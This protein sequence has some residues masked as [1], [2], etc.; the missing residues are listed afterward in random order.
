MAAS[1]PGLV[2]QI[3]RS[4]VDPAT[5]ELEAAILRAN[6][7]AAMAGLPDTLNPAIIDP[8]K[9]RA[10]VHAL[11]LSGTAALG[12]R[13]LLFSPALLRIGTSAPTTVASFSGTVALQVV[14][15]HGQAVSA[16]ATAKV[17]CAL[18]RQQ[19]AAARAAFTGAGPGVRKQEAAKPADHA[20]LVSLSEAKSR[21]FAIA[22]VWKENARA[23]LDC[24]PAD[25]AA[26]KDLDAA[27]RAVS[28][29]VQA[30]RTGMPPD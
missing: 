2:V 20:G 11:T 30:P 23:A 16:R 3:G 29:T 21:Q 22:T 19:A 8:A 6:G 10:L 5:P 13:A 7:S 24:A 25:A 17:D 1:P 18:A 15:T 4:Q 27:E 14:D 28:A 12:G 9:A 26:R